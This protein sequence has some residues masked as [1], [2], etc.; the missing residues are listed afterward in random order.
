MQL[1][2]NI[3]FMES[4]VTPVP[5]LTVKEFCCIQ[6]REIGHSRSFFS[7]IPHPKC[8]SYPAFRFLSQPRIRVQIWR[9]PLPR[10]QFKL[11]SRQRFPNPTPYFG[12]TPYPEIHFQTEQ[13]IYISN[14]NQG[15]NMMIGNI[16]GKT[17][18]NDFDVSSNNPRNP[19]NSWVKGKIY[20]L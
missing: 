2:N 13:K 6:G 14:E 20:R 1:S 18:D 3:K 5:G 19:E 4:W 8:C 10:Q 11:V 12:R 7:R 17:R 9:F 16:L 15:K